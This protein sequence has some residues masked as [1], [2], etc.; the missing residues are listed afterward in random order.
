MIN[1]EWK[2]IRIWIPTLRKQWDKIEE[3]EFWDFVF[4]ILNMLQMYSAPD[5]NMMYYPNHPDQF[6]VQYPNMLRN[7]P[8]K[9]IKQKRINVVLVC[10]Q[11][12]CCWFER[13]P[14]ALCYL[15]L[16]TA[17]FACV[18]FYVCPC[19]HASALST[20][21]CLLVSCEDSRKNSCCYA[22]VNVDLNK[23]TVNVLYIRGILHK[24][25]FSLKGFTVTSEICF[26]SSE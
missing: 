23:Q 20:V 21:N 22:V 10:K 1:Q 12:V 18:L 3:H 17:V 7:S 13:V 26:Q 2:N 15:M 5:E 4:N 11:Q 24:V 9:Y 14:L 16:I 6:H 8:R 19:C 25:R